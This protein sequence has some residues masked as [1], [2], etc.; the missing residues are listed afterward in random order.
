MTGLI[1][2]SVHRTADG[3]CQNLC[4][5]RNRGGGPWGILAGPDQVGPLDVSAATL[6]AML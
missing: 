6:F 4:Q 1:A 5:G 3:R 2:R